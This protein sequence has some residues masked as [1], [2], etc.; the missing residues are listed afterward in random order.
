MFVS[1]ILKPLRRQ[2]NSF[3][4]SSHNSPTIT[5]GSNQAHGHKHQHRLIILTIS[6]LKRFSLCFLKWANPG[7]FLFLFSSFSHHNSNIH[8]KSIDVLMDW[9]LDRRMVGADA[10]SPISVCT[11]STTL[12]TSLFI[13]HCKYHYLSLSLSLT[14]YLSGAGTTR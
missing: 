2:Q 11:F 4:T 13:S 9:T 5:T 3:R 12:S 14:I 8:W 1:Y 10:C 6:A 7:L